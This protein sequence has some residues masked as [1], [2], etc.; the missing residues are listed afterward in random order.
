MKEPPKFEIGAKVC[1]ID[2][3]LGLVVAGNIFSIE[4]EKVDN[5][6]HYKVEDAQGFTRTFP[7]EELYD[8][9]D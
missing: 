7:E 3:T 9:L 1:W 5:K 8:L 6:Y 2:K 4:Q